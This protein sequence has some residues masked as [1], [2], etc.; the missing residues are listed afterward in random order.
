MFISDMLI[1]DML[2]LDMQTKDSTV[3]HANIQAKHVTYIYKY[4]IDVN[5]S[6]FLVKMLCIRYGE[7]YQRIISFTCI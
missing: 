5:L 2:I 4:A 1:S 6:G 3:H 7:K